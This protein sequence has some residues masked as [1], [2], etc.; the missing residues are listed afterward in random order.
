[1]LLQVTDTHPVAA[2]GIAAL[3]QSEPQTAMKVEEGVQQLQKAE[4]KQKQSGMVLCVM[5]LLAAIVIL[6]LLVVFK[7]IFL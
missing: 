6:I 4:R 3:R 7:A 2:S 5:L 1:M